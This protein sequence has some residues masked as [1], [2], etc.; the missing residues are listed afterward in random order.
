MFSDGHEIFP[1]QDQI[2]RGGLGNLIKAPLGKHR[3]TGDWCLF[4]DEDLTDLDNPYEVLK[5][6]STIHVEEYLQNEF[7]E[8][9]GDPKT[10]EP[11][12]HLNRP[13]PGP[14]DRIP[15]AKDCVQRVLIEGSDKGQRNATAIILA[16]ELRNRGVNQEGV[17]GV[18]KWVWNPHNRPQLSHE[19]ISRVAKSAFQDPNR[20]YGCKP[21][22]S[23]RQTIT[24]L[25]YENCAYHSL[26]RTL[27]TGEVG[28][29]DTSV[30]KHTAINQTEEGKEMTEPNSQEELK[31]GGVSEQE[32]IPR[33]N[34]SKGTHS[35]SEICDCGSPLHHSGGCA[36]CPVCGESSCG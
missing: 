33:D 7:P 23:L 35:R 19:E 11:S 1:K 24:C 12:I 15:L 13:D 28:K 29:E 25:G 21:E 2:A 14:F 32:G 30:E 22:G 27:K 3:L 20:E 10:G 5:E 4:V 18:L 36:Y 17:E 26:L 9:F 34:H 31:T 16:T 8:A 6:V